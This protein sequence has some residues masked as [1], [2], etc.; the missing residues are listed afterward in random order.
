MYDK[1]AV[2]KYHLKNK[3]KIRLKQKEWLLENNDEQRRKH[4]EWYNRTRD[5]RNK[6]RREYCKKIKNEVL[7]HY[8]GNPPKCACCG[9]IH[10]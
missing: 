10:I 9:E 3:E 8:G 7:T 5:E 1:K 2:Q 6:V 4:S